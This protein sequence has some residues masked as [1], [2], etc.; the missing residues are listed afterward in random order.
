MT[1]HGNAS[2]A[3]GIDI[4]VVLRTS[5]PPVKISA[6]CKA[7]E[8]LTL[9]RHQKNEQTNARNIESES[10]L[11]IKIVQETFISELCMST[12]LLSTSFL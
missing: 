1:L 3:P 5:N 6:I 11:V 8:A 12:F 2:P 10:S 7:E 9:P 4:R